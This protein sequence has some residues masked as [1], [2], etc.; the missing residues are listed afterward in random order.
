MPANNNAELAFDPEEAAAVLSRADSRLAKVIRRAGPFT[1]RPE[2]MHSP[3]QS[4]LRA[5]VYQQLSGKAAATI[6][7]RVEALFPGG[8]LRPDAVLA[9]S[10]ESLRG[11]GMSRGKVAA[12]KDLAANTR[13]GTVPALP[14]RA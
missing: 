6:F 11:A 4:L 12:V 5:I 7:S 14:R 2:K 8:R 10:D 9:A 1:M 13:D 3:F